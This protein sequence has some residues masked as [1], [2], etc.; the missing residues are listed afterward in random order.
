MTHSPR[1][2]FGT[3]TRDTNL[4]TDRRKSSAG[5]GPAT[6]NVGSG[7]RASSPRGTIGRSPRDTLEYIVGHDQA[8][9]PGRCGS[10]GALLSP[11]VKGGFIGTSRRL[12]RTPEPQRPEPGPCSYDVAVP[13]RG[14][15]LPSARIG[16]ARRDTMEYIARGDMGQRSG[17]SPRP[18][19][20]PRGRSQ[21]GVIGSAPR[22]PAAGSPKGSHRTC[23]E[24]TSPGPLHY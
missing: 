5:P 3:A 21:G 12:S 17:H 4:E 10:T 18:A 8:P 22:W 6:Y 13:E 1:A 11:R 9:Q 19:T 15:R 24:E 23:H 14:S 2:T 16:N 7:S 20:S